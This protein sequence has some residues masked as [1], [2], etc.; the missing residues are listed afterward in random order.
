M[1][2]SKELARK[3]AEIFHKATLLNNSYQLLMDNRL[4]WLTEEDSTPVRYF[5][6]P[7]ASLLRKFGVIMLSLLPFESLL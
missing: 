2:N 4:A 5:Q 1:V 6:E 7:K 3:T